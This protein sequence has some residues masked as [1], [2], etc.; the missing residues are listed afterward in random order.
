[1]EGYQTNIGLGEGRRS[2][3]LW[4]V[5]GKSY[6]QCMNLDFLFQKMNDW[7]SRPENPFEVTV[8]VPVTI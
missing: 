7:H 5:K 4:N 8:W 6:N 1:M 2:L 3:F